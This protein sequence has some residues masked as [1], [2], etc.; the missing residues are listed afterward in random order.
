MLL[1]DAGF[2]E[3]V[4]LLRCSSTGPMM[5][6]GR[7]FVGDELGRVAADFAVVEIGRTAAVFDERGER[8]GNSSG[9]YLEMRSITWWRPG[10]E[11]SARVRVRSQVVGGPNRGGGHDF[12]LLKSRPASLCAFADKAEAPV[13]EVGVSEL[14]DHAV[15]DASRGA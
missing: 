12:D 2:A 14:E 15:A 4:E 8:G 7:Q 1:G 11:N 10:Q 5:Q 3:P 9:L 13:D 6:S